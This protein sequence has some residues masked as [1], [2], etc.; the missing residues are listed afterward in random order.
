MQK[1]KFNFKHSI[2]KKS[3]E[4]LENKDNLE[5]IYFK[6]KKTTFDPLHT[7]LNYEKKLVIF[8]E[9]PGVTNN[10]IDMKINQNTILITGRKNYIKH[11]MSMQDRENW[12]IMDDFGFFKTKITVP[13]NIRQENFSAVHKNGLLEI[14]IAKENNKFRYAV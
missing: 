3:S 4:N 8:V 1:S 9:L 7:I 5:H 11:Y 10:Q 2:R 13:C 12:G 6:S 14:T